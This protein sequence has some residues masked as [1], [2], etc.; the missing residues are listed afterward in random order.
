MVKE[1]M[2]GVREYSDGHLVELREYDGRDVVL[3]WNQGAH[4]C[5]QVDLLDLIAWIRKNKPEILAESKP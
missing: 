2:S 4:D 1:V 5:T 3:A